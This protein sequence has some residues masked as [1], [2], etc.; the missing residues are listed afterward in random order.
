MFR[1]VF[2]FIGCFFVCSTQAQV[3]ISEIA[4]MG[5]QKSHNDEWIE[6]RNQSLETIDLTGWTL[7][8]PDKSPN[9]NLSGKIFSADFFLLERTDDTSTPITADQIYTGSLKNEGEVLILKDASG[10]TKDQ[11]P[12]GMWSAGNNETKQTM[13]RYDFET[14]KT[15]ASSTP[16]AKN[17]AEN[18]PPLRGNKPHAFIEIQGSGIT[19]TQKINFTASKSSAAP[20]T[21]IIDYVWSR[22][23]KTNHKKQKNEV[24]SEKENPPS[25]V[26]DMHAD[27]NKNECSNTFY[28]V[29]LSVRDEN[30]LSDTDMKTFPLRWE[31]DRCTIYPKKSADFFSHNKKIIPDNWD[32]D[33]EAENEFFAEFLAAYKSPNN[34]PYPDY[35]EMRIKKSAENFAPQVFA[36]DQFFQRTGISKNRLSKNIGL[37][38][39]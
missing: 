23:L 15:S 3:L 4:W 2:F 1:K 27:L 5:T 34:I 17:S 8:T 26:F 14:W 18:F 29:H 30:N 13:E 7:T 25:I 32:E 12:S 28:E 37:I 19:S 35:G 36:R 11:T 20:E 6:L 9:I 38:L 39:T 24:F 16:R 21:K 31:K 22:T 33:F 10:N